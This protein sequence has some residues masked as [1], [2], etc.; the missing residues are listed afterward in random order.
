VARRAH[1]RASSGTHCFGMAGAGSSLSRTMSPVTDRPHEK[2]R[3]KLHRVQRVPGNGAQAASEVATRHFSSRPR[4][5][6]LRLRRIRSRSL[7]IPSSTTVESIPE[8]RGALRP[9]ELE[10]GG[11]QQRTY[12][13]RSRT[14]RPTRPVLQQLPRHHAVNV[15]QQSS[16]RHASHPGMSWRPVRCRTGSAREVNRD[17]DRLD[18]QYADRHRGEGMRAAR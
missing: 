8:H 5:S 1:R 17:T 14:S 10:H 16:G 15:A 12:R 18:D 4:Q 3:T 2:L 11:H 13:H 9:G 6:G 7:H